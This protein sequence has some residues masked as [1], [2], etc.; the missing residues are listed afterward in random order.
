[1]LLV[2]DE[3]AVPF[4]GCFAAKDALA[5]RQRFFTVHCGNRPHEE[6]ALYDSTVARLVRVHFTLAGGRFPPLALAFRGQLR[7]ARLGVGLRTS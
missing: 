1:M 4:R 5:C 2:T 6:L 3:E 7:T